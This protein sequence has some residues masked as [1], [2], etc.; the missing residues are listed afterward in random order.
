VPFLF[1]RPCK[2]SDRFQRIH[3]IEDATEKK[4]FD[5]NELPVILHAVMTYTLSAEQRET[6]AGICIDLASSYLDMLRCQGRKIFYLQPVYS[7]K[8]MASDA[9]A[10]LFMAPP[11]G[12]SPHFK[13]FLL[14]CRPELQSPAGCL[15]VLR[16]VCGQRMQQHL[17]IFF[18]EKDPEGAKLYRNLRLAVKR[19]KN[20]ALHKNIMGYLFIYP[21][22]SDNPMRKRPTML[23]L[24]RLAN[25]RFHPSMHVDELVQIV[26]QE[27][28]VAFNMPV[29]VDMAD[30]YYL[31]KDFRATCR[32]VQDMMSPTGTWPLQ[33][34]ELQTAM[35]LIL[36][37]IRDTILERYSRDGKL[38][39]KEAVALYA[40]LCDVARDLAMGEGGEKNYTYIRRHWPT[41]SEDEYYS[42]IRKAFEYLVR[43]FK[44]RLSAT[45]QQIF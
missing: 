6:L 36:A 32:S 10:D 4:K 25:G 21:D 23:E 29:A 41:L 39:G 34:A 7:A 42:S 1:Y 35:T 8:S 5:I 40:A 26:L 27:A 9:I 45:G 19:I 44:D 3:G 17:R 33:W 31:I 15:I 24:Q 12:V 2:G 13:K 28:Y 11:P 22:T 30:L 43:I 38:T 16:R 37:D 14:R 20:A 18:Y